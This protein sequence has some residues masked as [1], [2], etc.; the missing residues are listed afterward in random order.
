MFVLHSI[1]PIQRYK[2]LLPRSSRDNLDSERSFFNVFCISDVD[3]SVPISPI[4]ILS[5]SFKADKSETIAPTLLLACSSMIRLKESSSSFSTILL[6]KS[7]YSGS[8]IFN[9]DKFESLK[10]IM[11]FLLLKSSNCCFQ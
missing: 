4:A 8:V 1:K 11:R 6:Y 2:I 3:L 7:I 5:G 9:V 10:F